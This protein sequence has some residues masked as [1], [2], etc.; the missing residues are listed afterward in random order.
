MSG[1]INQALIAFPLIGFFISI[2]FPTIYSLATNS[3]PK[4]YASAISGI[5]CTA[6]I[7]G[8]VIG[9]VIAAVAE[10]NQGTALVPNWDTGL[11]VAFACYAYIFVLSVFAKEEK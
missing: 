5:L 4:E 7:G 3:F 2:M 11:L 1:D 10:A 6:I 8:A 9:P